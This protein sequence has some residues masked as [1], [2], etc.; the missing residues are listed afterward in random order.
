MEASEKPPIGVIGVGW[1]GLVTGACFAEIGRPVVAV[2]IDAGKI[3][4]LRSGA[5]LPIHEPGLPE[6]V[7][8]TRERLTF[9]TEMD[10]VLAASRLLFC[11]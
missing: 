10:E 7:E 8:R 2:D 4:A 3:E 9:T 11:C 6:L 1:V 5:P